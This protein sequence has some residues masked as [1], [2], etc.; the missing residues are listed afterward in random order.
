M[1]ED[2]IPLGGG[3]IWPILISGILMFVFYLCGW[4]AL[5]TGFLI[6]FLL[7]GFR[8]LF[9]VIAAFVAL[10]RLCV[11][12]SIDGAVLG[13]LMIWIIILLLFEIAA[14]CLIKEEAEKGSSEQ[15]R[16]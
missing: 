10:A 15:G 5:G 14:R 6:L 7:A 4:S 3:N 8:S 13:V 9:P 2:D 16:K 1:R 12:L 11:V